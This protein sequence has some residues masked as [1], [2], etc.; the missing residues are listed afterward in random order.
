MLLCLAMLSSAFFV[1]VAAADDVEVKPYHVYSTAV[2]QYGASRT[3]MAELTFYPTDGNTQK[4]NWN[5][6][7]DSGN[8]ETASMF[9][10]TMNYFFVN[11][12]NSAILL[13]G[14]HYDLTFS[15]I[16]DNST[17]AFLNSSS[18]PV[19]QTT[20]NKVKPTVQIVLY[21]ES[22]QTYNLDGEK[23][24]VSS[25]YH[26]ISGGHDVTENIVKIG[27]SLSYNL[28]DVLDTVTFDFVKVRIMGTLGENIGNE[29]AM[30][31]GKTDKSDELLE[32][33]NG[34]I[35]TIIGWLQDIWGTI[36]DLG[37]KIASLPETIWSY[38]EQPLTWI[39]ESI[40]NLPSVIIE[41]L[42]NLFIPSSTQIIDMKESWNDVLADRF[43]AVYESA[44]LLTDCWDGIM[45]ADQT[46]TIKVPSVGIRL[47]ENN[48]FSFGGYE[49]R[50]VPEGFGSLAGTVKMVSGLMGTLAF[51]NG[52]RKRYDEVMGVET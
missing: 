13:G 21:G 37:S 5:K 6:E 14:N 43:G 9:G 19:G 23:S 28:K 33:Q 11:D 20:L 2:L 42:K 1:N 27:V 29:Y 22:G 39:G 34:L 47:P 46:N 44:S 45:Q 30:T 32:E 51:V 12:D 31:F 16:F 8:V 24:F 15:K 49:V 41:G 17:I 3:Q 4:V 10:I 40:V 52:L 18:A 7:F 26:T 50:V 36:K 38:L 35:A 25:N 48:G